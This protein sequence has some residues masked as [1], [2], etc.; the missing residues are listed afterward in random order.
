[1]DSIW[2]DR[3]KLP[4]FPA[5]TQNQST[6]VL[7]IGGGIAG[8]LCAYTLK[9]AGIDV[10]LVEAKQICSG[11][12]GKTTAKITAQHGLI[13]DKLLRRF[14]VE[15]T[16]RFLDFNQNAVNAYHTLCREIDCD[17]TEQDAYL[18]SLY[19]ESVLQNELSALQSLG[20]QAEFVRDLPL[21]FQTVGAIRFQNQ[22]QFHPLKFLSAIAQNLTIYENTKVLELMPGIVRTNRGTIRAEKIVVATHFPLLNKHGSYFLKLYQQRSYV[23]GLQNAT[24]VSGMYIGAEYP[25]LSLRNEND[26][27]LFGGCGHRTGKDGG[28]WN[29]LSK[30]A[31]RYYPNAKIAYRWATQDCMTL[32]GLPY[33]GQYSKNTPNLYVLTGFQKWGMSTALAGAEVIRDLIIGKENPYAS[34]FSP[35]RTILHPQLA[36]N[37][38]EATKNLL[39]FRTPR[40]PH[41]GCAL[42]WNKQEHSWDCSCHGSRFSESGEV[43]DNPAT[44]DKHFK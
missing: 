41:L 22:A 23:L 15:K 6:D 8:I 37:G 31:K 1:M 14:G 30:Y 12:T 44:D 36:I 28:G 42:K 32:D 39:T 3:L 27:L 33:I 17:F 7:I 11:V 18:Y 4:N 20:A 38:F 9:Q 21:P 43:L 25:N 34:L 29:E 35:S 2:Y 10:V 5:L 19:D 24:R 26:F 13:F 16:R 40:C